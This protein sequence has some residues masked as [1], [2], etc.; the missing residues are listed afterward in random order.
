[1]R[2]SEIAKKSHKAYILCGHISS[3]TKK[4]QHFNDYYDIIESKKA[5]AIFERGI[6]YG[7][8]TYNEERL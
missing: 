3:S 5:I 4:Y 1:V 8:A 6:Y 2:N 7:A